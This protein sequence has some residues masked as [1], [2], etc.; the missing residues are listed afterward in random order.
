MS[1][2]SNVIWGLGVVAV[3]TGLVVFLNQSKPPVEEDPLLKVPS[4]LV[5]DLTEYSFGT[6][7]MGAGK[8][9]RAYKVRNDGESPMRIT[10]L[11]TSCMCT[12]AKITTPRESKGP[13]GMPGHGFSPSINSLLNPG[14]EAVV[15]VVFDPAAHGPAGVGKIQRVVVLESDKGRPFELSFSANVTP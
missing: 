12:E 13:F 5:S 1:K 15:D 8:V 2:Y 10:K 9:S 11:Y 7:S 6:I 4:S 3:I 14:E